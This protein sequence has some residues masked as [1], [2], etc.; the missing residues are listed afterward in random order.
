MNLLYYLAGFAGVV[1]L[2]AVTGACE[3]VGIIPEDIAQIL[4]GAEVAGPLGAVAMYASQN[5]LGRTTQN[6]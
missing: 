1:G 2:I 6:E 5:G 3:Q 4:Y